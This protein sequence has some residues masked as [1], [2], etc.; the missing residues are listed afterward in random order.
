MSAFRVGV[1][2]PM[3]PV[4]RHPVKSLPDARVVLSWYAMQDARAVPFG[5][6][7][8]CHMCGSGAKGQRQYRVS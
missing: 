1:Y 3:P 8:C 2:V 6:E 4:S 5:R 7:R